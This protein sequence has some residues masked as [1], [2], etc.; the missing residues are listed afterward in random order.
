MMMHL[1]FILNFKRSTLALMTASCVCR[2]IASLAAC[3]DGIR[4]HFTTFSAN[5][6]SLQV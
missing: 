4:G 5:I 2:L 1:V 6:P 3:I